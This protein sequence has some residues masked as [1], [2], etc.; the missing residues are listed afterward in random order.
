MICTACSCLCDDIE[1]RNGEILNACE[2]GCRHLSR[3]KEKR[4]RPIVDR[5]EVDVDKAIE[6]TIEILKTSKSP[7]IYGLD[8]STVEA[9]KVAIKIAE[10]LNCYIDDNSSFC[11][12]EF[13]EAILKKEVKTSTLDEVRDRAYVLIY[14]G[15]NPYHSLPRHMSRYT[16]YPRG[17]KRN[18]GY[19][20]DRYLVVVDIR[21]TETAKLAKKNAKFIKV[22]N[23]LELVDSFIK[24]LEGKV[25]KYDTASIL[26]E[27]KKSD[28]NA[29]FG[30]LGLKYGL[31][32]NLK[33]FTEM[34][35]RVNEVVP[36]F[37]L[38]AGFHSNMRGFNETLFEKVEAV[39]K[40]SFAERKSSAAFA[41]T[42]LI[43]N[44]KIDSAVIVGTN[45]ISSLPFE[46]SKNLLKIKKVVIDPFMTETAK[47]ADIFIPTA[48]SGI[49]TQGE[50]VRSDGVRVKLSPIF[51]SEIDDVYVLKKILEGL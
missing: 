48:F 8:T 47:N 4:A 45:P 18:R 17:A 46:V 38:P 19:D 3:F 30:G 35:R 25:S 27:M 49:E 44:Q 29:V 37:F 40:F 28:F 33:M 32:G 21:K 43:K 2:R 6:A 34:M 10:K 13:V 15:A 9:Q 39:N 42:E 12:G 22:E 23:D 16:Y 31:K 1:I 7:A 41:F 36:L 26:R 20:E 5:K 11:L 14:W 24:S 51:K 50:M